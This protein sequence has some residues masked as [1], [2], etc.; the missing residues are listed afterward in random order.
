MELNSFGDNM[1]SK[2][3]CDTKEEIKRDNLQVN[4]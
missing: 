3:E 4:K 2:K 1:K